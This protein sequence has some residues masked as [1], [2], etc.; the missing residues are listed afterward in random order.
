MVHVA[1][2]PELSLNQQIGAEAWFENYLSTLLQRDVK[3]LADLEKKVALLPQMLRI[4]A[5]QAGSLMNEVNL[6]RAV[7]ANAVTAKAYRTMLKLLFLTFDIPP[8]FLN[9]KRRLVKASKGYVIDSLLLCHLIGYDLPT[10]VNKHPDLYGHVVEKFVTTELK[11]LLSVSKIRT[12]L[13]HFRTRDNKEVDFVLE[14]ANGEI[15]GIEV[16][17]ATHVEPSDFNGLCTLQSL[18]Q[19]DFVIGVVLYQ[20]EALV[21]VD[22]RLWAMPMQV[23][24]A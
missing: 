12:S 13:M 19:G 7:G 2:F 5:S 23:L 21:P 1:T 4:L 6:A 18:T 10:L 24:W 22:A 16:K 8:W 9:V 15:V 3:M 14:R 17:A 20:G 11:K